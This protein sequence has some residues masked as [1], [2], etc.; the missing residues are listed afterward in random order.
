MTRVFMLV[1]EIRNSVM[2]SSM[3]PLIFRGSV[4]KKF[5]RFSNNRYNKK[6]KISE[7]LCRVVTLEVSQPWFC[8]GFGL[9]NVRN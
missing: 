6:R 3:F 1:L 4:H 8:F 7:E 9:K 5:C 2:L